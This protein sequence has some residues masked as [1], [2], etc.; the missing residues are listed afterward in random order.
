MLLPSFPRFINKLQHEMQMKCYQ[1]NFFFLRLGST[2]RVNIG[3]KIYLMAEHL[4][5]S[6]NTDDFLAAHIRK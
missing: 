2:M 6:I 1:T 3:G 5:V 4:I